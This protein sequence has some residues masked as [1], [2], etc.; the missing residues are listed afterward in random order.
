MSL[1]APILHTPPAVAQQPNGD[2]LRIGLVL[3]DPAARTPAM[4]GTERGV[5]LG[6]E[7]AARSARLF[8]RTV[9]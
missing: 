4:T 1:A 6:V 3:A 5:R 9:V 8:G 7:E 2:T